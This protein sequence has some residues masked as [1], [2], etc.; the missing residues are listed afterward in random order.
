MILNF[1]RRIRGSLRPPYWSYTIRLCFI[2]QKYLKKGEC[3]SSTGS[4][5]VFQEEI[6]YEK[7]VG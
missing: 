3:F 6:V 5:N 2:E 7:F 4:N 1:E